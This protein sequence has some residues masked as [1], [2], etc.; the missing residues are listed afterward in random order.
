MIRDLRYALRLLASRPGFTAVAVLTLALGIGA[1][2]AIFT[3]VNAV[4]LRSFP[5]QDPDRLMLLVERT[6]KFPTVTTSWLNFRDWR[7]QGRSFDAVA[8]YRNLTMTI[9]GGSEPERLPA[10]HVTASLLPMLGGSP[11]LGRTFSDA[12]DR[13]G[14][15]G[16]AVITDA[17]WRRRFGADASVLGRA[18]TLDDQ[19]YTIVGVLPPG[20]Q[21]MLPADIL[22]PMGPWAASLPDDRSWHPGIFALGRL[23]AGTT[24]TQAQ[25][26]MN[27]ISER[28]S[29]Q[30]PTFNTGVSADVVQLHEYAVQNVRRSL[31]LL[32]AAVAF[33]LLI[34][35]ANVA[36]LLLARSI[37]R[38]REIAIRTAVGASRTQIASQLMIESLVLATAGGAAGILIAV[39]CLPLVSALGNAPGVA[40]IRLDPAALAYTVALSLATGIVFGFAPA[41]QT[42][43]GGMASA[44]ND[45]GRGAGAGRSHRRLRGLLVVAEIGL[46][47]ML[48][49]SAG[50]L[51]RSLLR[52]QDVSPGFDPAHVLL[53]DLPMS[54]ASYGKNE[55]RNAFADQL[56]AALRS[57]AGVQFAELATAPPFSGAG[58]SLHFNIIGR[59]PKGP[60]EFVITGYRA[61]TSGYFSAL[62][63]PLRA[64]RVFTD[65]DRDGSPPVSVVNE[66]FVRRFFNGSRDEALR[67]HIQI[68]GEP[69]DETPRMQIVGIVGD[70]KQALEA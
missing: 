19:P 11:A 70:T 55:A 9:A 61:I 24:P 46:A 1:N 65:R 21:L 40:P 68:G 7:D 59:P 35:C 49:V 62:K 18:I 43:R 67:A 34:A 42:T 20:F 3:V 33:V 13:A 48:L 47:M 56:L 60:D 15:P 38:Q 22:L 2:T 8:A 44:M 39:W 63:V 25:S 14:A 32:V 30:Y 37:G 27:V 10:K 69:N 50:L 54:A 23:K 57:K 53:G 51:T 45:G 64:G 29:K 4:L 66:T 6:T 31:L 12:D 41:M 58:S 52:L 36:N 26:E 16:V 17:L 28:L 5:F